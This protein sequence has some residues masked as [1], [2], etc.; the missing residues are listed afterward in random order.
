[1][2]LE[3]ARM[4]LFSSFEVRRRLKHAGEVKAGL[5]VALVC[6]KPKR[7]FRSRD[8]VHATLPRTTEHASSKRDFRWGRRD[9]RTVVKT[10]I[11]A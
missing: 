7:R 3:N 10:R 1:M 4:I 9:G 6:G 8:G 11:F 2:R 5:C